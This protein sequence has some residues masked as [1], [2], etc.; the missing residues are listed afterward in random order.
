MPAPTKYY[1]VTF[2]LED[3]QNRQNE[4]TLAEDTLRFRFGSR[5]Y[6]KIVKQCA[7]LRTNQWASV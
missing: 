1:L 2:D 4:Y 6:W 3:S 7:I 5:N